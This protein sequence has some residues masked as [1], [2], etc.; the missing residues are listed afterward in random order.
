RVPLAQAQAAPKEVVEHRVEADVTP[1]GLREPPEVAFGARPVLLAERAEYRL[2]QEEEVAHVDAGGCAER[3]P[4]LHLLV[5][6]VRLAALPVDDRR[7][8]PPHDAR[9][10]REVRAV[11]DL[12]VERLVQ[13]ASAREIAR[14]PQTIEEEL[15]G[16]AD[17]GAG[18]GRVIERAGRGLG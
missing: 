5:A 12:V 11:R 16:C 1:L 9:E 3:E 14:P 17:A 6:N 2:R 15:R 18:V 4:A 7:A 8:R 13:R 10:R